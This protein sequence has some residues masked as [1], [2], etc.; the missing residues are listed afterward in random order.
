MIVKVLQGVPFLVDSSTKQIYAYEK[1]IPQT[2]LHLGSYDPAT[3]TFQ[4]L[5][6]WKELYQAKVDAYKQTEKPRSRLPTATAAAT[7]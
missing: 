4:L 7:R 5:P 2:P 1:P 3:E 6:N